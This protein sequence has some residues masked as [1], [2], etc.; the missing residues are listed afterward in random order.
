[1]PCRF[2]GPNLLQALYGATDLFVVGKFNGS[3]AIACSIN[4]AGDFLLTGY[5]KMDTAGVAIATVSAQLISSLCGSD[6]SLIT[7]IH[8][9]ISIF[10]VRI[11]VAWVLS[12][13]FPE[14]LLPM[15][16]ASPLGSLMSILILGIYF[17]LAPGR[18]QFSSSHTDRKSR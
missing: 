1:M 15:G 2:W 5:L 12:R 14:S 4:V 18:P 16:L 9:V 10:L 11:P 3:S 8:S 17:K 6:R 7:F 13:A